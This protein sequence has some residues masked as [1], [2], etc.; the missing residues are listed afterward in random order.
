MKVVMLLED[1]TTVEVD[2]VVNYNVFMEEDSDELW[3]KDEQ[4]GFEEIP[5]EY[6]NDEVIPKP[7]EGELFEVRPDEIDRSRFEEP[8]EDKMQEKTRQ[9]I[10]EAFSEADKYPEVYKKSFFTLIP[11]RTW[12]DRVTF[13]ELA[14]YAKELGGEIAT[15]V[16]QALEWA[17]RIINGESWEDLCNKTFEVKSE[18][19]ILWKNGNYK[20]VGEGI[21]VD[22]EADLYIWPAAS[23]CKSDWIHSNIEC[24]HIVPLVVIEK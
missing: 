21:C 14:E 8:L 10:R 12:D 5:Q 23:I 7:K 16:H 22:A 1:G 15:W 3:D 24:R 13:G 9:L 20:V 11:K 19:A 18:R 2:N 17:Q 4:T 6:E